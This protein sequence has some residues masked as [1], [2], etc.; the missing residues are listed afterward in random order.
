MLGDGRHVLDISREAGIVVR[1]ADADVAVGAFTGGPQPDY[2]CVLSADHRLLLTGDADGNAHLWD[3]EGRSFLRTLPGDGS[4]VLSA[5]FDG[6]SRVVVTGSMDALVAVW[7]TSSGKRLGKLRT[8]DPGAHAVSV[9]PDGRLALTWRRQQWVTD[10]SRSAKPVARLWDLETFRAV[11]PR[12]AGAVYG[13]VWR[14]DSSRFYT[15]AY[16]DR[17]RVVRAWQPTDFSVDAALRPGSVWVRPAAYYPDEPASVT[18]ASQVDRVD[19]TPHA[20]GMLPLDQRHGVYSV[21]ISRDG[22]TF[23]A[24]SRGSVDIW[25]HVGGGAET[26]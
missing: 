10:R 18:W 26:E 14:P 11:G 2:P 6:E 12:S 4:R 15:S 8:R 16:E 22:S 9:S 20:S 7:D 13:C 17:R 3:V 1:D 5:S 24:L 21:A 23:A 25:R 19:D